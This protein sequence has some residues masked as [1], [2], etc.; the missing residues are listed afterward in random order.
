MMLRE[1]VLPMMAKARRKVK[2]TAKTNVKSASRKFSDESGSG[3]VISNYL[4]VDSSAESDEDWMTTPSERNDKTRTS[5]SIPKIVHNL[6][7]TFRAV[8]CSFV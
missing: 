5:L 6:V 1:T 7:R 3:R 8:Q 2:M 4:T